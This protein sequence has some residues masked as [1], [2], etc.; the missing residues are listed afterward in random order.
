MI[1]NYVKILKMLG[2]R[3]EVCVSVYFTGGLKLVSQR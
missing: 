3:L 2:D 1:T